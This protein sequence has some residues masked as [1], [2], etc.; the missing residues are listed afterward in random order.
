M[1]M[2]QTVLT[3]EVRNDYQINKIFFINKILSIHDK[4]SIA[5]NV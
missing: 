4:T 3:T 2:V 5:D 1:P